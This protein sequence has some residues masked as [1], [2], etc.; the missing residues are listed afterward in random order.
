VDHAEVRER[1]ELAAAEPGGIDR[2]M[3]GDTNDAAAV[4][5][6]LAG[7]EACREEFARLRRTSV[8]LRDAIS[9]LPPPD[10]RD[11]TLAYVAALGRERRPAT[12]SALGPAYSAAPLAESVEAPVPIETRRR[13]RGG[14]IGRALP[15]LAAAAAI[16]IAVGA[17]VLAV[18]TSRDSELRTTADELA[19]LNRVAASTVS[20]ETQPDAASVALVGTAGTAARGSLLFSPSTRQL[21]VVATDLVAP[22]SGKEYRCWLEVDGARERVGR[23]FFAGDVAYWAGPVE[24]LPRAV[25]GTRFGVSLVDADADSLGGDPV[26]AG[27]L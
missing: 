19:G 24:A 8:L 25:S 16:V 18:N 23:M 6:H 14:G 1:L 22:P 21:V 3:A 15:W 5:G 20:I 4:A 27:Q 13:A 2:L 7:C 26:L 12:A 10:L 17:T 9:T 11:R